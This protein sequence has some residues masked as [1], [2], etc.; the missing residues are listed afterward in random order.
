M[1]DEKEESDPGM[2]FL[3]ASDQ[4]IDD[5]LNTPSVTNGLVP[6]LVKGEECTSPIVICTVQWFSLLLNL[7]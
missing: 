7:I 1:D 6:N 4:E 3:L 5:A 2:M